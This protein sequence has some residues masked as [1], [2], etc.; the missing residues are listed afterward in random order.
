VNP[1]SKISHCKPGFAWQ[2]ES[3]TGTRSA[4]L[5]VPTPAPADQGA[6]TARVVSPRVRVRVG[7]CLSLLEVLPDRAITRTG[8][9]TV[10]VTIV[11]SGVVLHEKV[12]ITCELTYEFDYRKLR[13]LRDGECT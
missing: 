9:C 7:N 4:D 6:G 1:A 12:L 11:Q 13:P 2:P 5:L 8:F 3:C 10:Y